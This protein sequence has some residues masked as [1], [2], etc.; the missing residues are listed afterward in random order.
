MSTIQTTHRLVF[1]ITQ[2][3]TQH[4]LTHESIT[5]D[6]K[7]YRNYTMTVQIESSLSLT[8]CNIKKKLNI[9]FCIRIHVCAYN[10]GLNAT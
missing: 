7:Y 10:T 1:H 6:L 9:F 3:H 2:Y 8:K 4:R 5:G